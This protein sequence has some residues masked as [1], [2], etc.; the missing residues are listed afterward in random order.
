MTFEVFCHA[1][2]CNSLR[3]AIG[4]V[5]QSPILF[6][7]TVINNVRY[8]RLSATDEEVY[9]ACKAAA[10]HDQIMGFTDGYMTRVGERGV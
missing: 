10:M 2:P 3:Q 6:D 1:D 5:P 9:S 4:I 8:A 7:D